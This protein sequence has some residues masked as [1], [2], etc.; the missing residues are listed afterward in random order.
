MVVGTCHQRIDWQRAGESFADRKPTGSGCHPAL[1]LGPTVSG[2]SAA[3][4][5]A[6]FQKAIDQQAKPEVDYGPQV[7]C[8]RVVLRGGRQVWRQG[9]INGIAEED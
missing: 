4:E 1:F 9:K 7:H 6:E 5:G 8:P 2:N 3:E